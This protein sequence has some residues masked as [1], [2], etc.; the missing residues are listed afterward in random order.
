MMFFNISIISL[1]R[2]LS[3]LSESP[4]PGVSTIVYSFP[5]PI[6]LPV[7]YFVCFVHELPPGHT[8]K[9]QVSHSV[10]RLYLAGH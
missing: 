8:G 9:V 10:S 7:A 2:L 4:K 6:Q 3:S 5:V 1:I